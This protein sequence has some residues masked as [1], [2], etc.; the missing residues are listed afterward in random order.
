MLS[1]MNYPL[2]W[3]YLDPARCLPNH[4]NS[5]AL[6]EGWIAQPA[7]FWSSLAYLF[8]SG[9]A[10]YSL[11]PL[12]QEARLWF[13]CLISVALTS[14]FAHS[15]M[16][17]LSIAFD[18]AAIST[19][20]ASIPI[21]QWS[22]QMNLR[23]NRM[24]LITFSLWIGLVAVLKDRSPVITVGACLVFFLLVIFNLLKRRSDMFRNVKMWSSLIAITIGFVLFL[25]DDF[26]IYHPNEDYLK[27]HTLWHLFSAFAIYQ[28]TICY[29]MDPEGNKTS[30]I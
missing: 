26:R 2:W 5:E 18:M 25:A 12:T 7:A 13:S 27:G 8:F 1:A 21:Y 10:L 17:E 3:N 15:S 14:F 24:Y 23:E 19:L 16:T 11:K 9:L 6:R 28:F 22:I 29:F 20:L 30:K 4:C